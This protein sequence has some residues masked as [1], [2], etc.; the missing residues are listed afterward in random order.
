MQAWNASPPICYKVGSTVPHESNPTFFSY[1]ISLLSLDVGLGPSKILPLNLA[2]RN[3]LPWN[4]TFCLPRV[5]LYV[6]IDVL[7]MPICL[8][9]VH[10]LTASAGGLKACVIMTLRKCLSL[11]LSVAVF[12]NRFTFQHWMGTLIVFAG[13][14]IFS[15]LPSPTTDKAPKQKKTLSKID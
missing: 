3:I 2:P 9:G 5:W 12:E 6:M 13:S 11:A 14:F 10:S 1:S 7:S 4:F 8:R 15:L